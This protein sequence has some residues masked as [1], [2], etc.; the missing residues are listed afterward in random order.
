MPIS[1]RD[2]EL[3][4]K[5]FNL[6]RSE[7]LFLDTTRFYE[8]LFAQDP[9][10]RGMFREDLGGQGMKFMTTLKTIVVALNDPEALQA[11]LKSLGESHAALSVVATNFKPMGEALI[12]TFR[13]LLGDEFT[14]EMEAAWR[15][16]YT[17]ISK[18][19]IK[20]GGIP[21]GSTR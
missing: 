3:V 14:P 10:L 9:D 18:E 4:T 6:A 5:S 2:I 15:T 19:M 11:K 8:N 7:Q 16:A 12:D 20:R 17:E 13:E 1:D 21:G